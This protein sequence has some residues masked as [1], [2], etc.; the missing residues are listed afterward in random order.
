MG[1]TKA[2][3]PYFAPVFSQEGV[4]GEALWKFILDALRSRSGKTIQPADPWT[5]LS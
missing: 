5:F 2:H 1:H 3:H 4:L